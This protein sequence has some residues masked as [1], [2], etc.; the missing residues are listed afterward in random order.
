VYVKDFRWLEYR[1]SSDGFYCPEHD[2]VCKFLD[3]HPK[4]Q[5]GYFMRLPHYLYLDILAL[6]EREYKTYF[7]HTPS[8]I[9][10]EGKSDEAR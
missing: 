10:E 4:Y 3:E 6:A 9:R 5:L 7:W 2:L 1:L 8:R